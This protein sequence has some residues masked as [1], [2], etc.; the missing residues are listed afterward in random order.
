MQRDPIR[1]T[2]VQREAYYAWFPRGWVCGAGGGDDSVGY[3]EDVL[4]VKEERA[5]EV[6][7]G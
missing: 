1:D 2:P 3:E 4:V 5:G 7:A 6:A